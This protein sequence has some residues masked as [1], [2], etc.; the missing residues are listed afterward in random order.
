MKIARDRIG[1]LSLALLAAVFGGVAMGQTPP[2]R[3]NAGGAA[4]FHA[5]IEI[6]GDGVKAVVIRVS[7]DEEPRGVTLVHSEVIPVS[8]ASAGG[9]AF[10]RRKTGELISTLQ[11]L[12]AR[13][14]DEYRV[15]A[16][17]LHLIGSGGIWADPPAELA[18]FIRAA[19]KKDLIALE[20]SDE[21]QLSIAGA[22]PRRE[23]IGDAWVDVRNS[24]V[25]IEIEG[26]AT[27][28]GYQI[29]KYRP[30]APPGYEFTVTNI[31]HGPASLAGEIRAG[32]NLPDFIRRTNA[33]RAASFKEALRKAGENNPGL[34]VRNR[35]YLSGEIVRAL[36]VSLYP[37]AKEN[38][39][40]LTAGDIDAFARKAFDDP[41]ALLDPNLSKVRDRKLLQEIREDLKLARSRLTPQQVVAGALM[42]KTLST[43]MNLREK[44]IRFVRHGH[45]SRVLTYLRLQVEK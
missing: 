27:R 20:A 44:N 6:G 28:G 29:L 40:P 11:K 26:G 38:F 30:P 7:Q 2:P 34:M 45:L 3:A 36:V 25:F 43:E 9:L 4:E 10:D 35:I 1:V 15:T 41:R 16:E 32:D 5:G 8:L 13:F 14:R 12:I 42:L 31:P 39:V 17:R 18:N 37:E 21:I 19:T 33:S 22:V 23:K 24:S